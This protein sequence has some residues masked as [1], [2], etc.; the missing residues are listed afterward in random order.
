[1]KQ[2]A[3]NLLIVNTLILGFF[4]PDSFHLVQKDGKSKSK[5]LPL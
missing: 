4:V 1:M 5:V 3:L 2:E